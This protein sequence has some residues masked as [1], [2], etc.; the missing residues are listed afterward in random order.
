M[1]SEVDAGRAAILRGSWEE[2][3]GPFERAL[4]AGETAEI[5]D[6]LGAA[7]RLLLEEEATR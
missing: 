6:G 3:R 2:A 5:L 1:I 4:E 7:A